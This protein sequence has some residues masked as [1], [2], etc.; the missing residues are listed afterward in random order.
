MLHFNH[1]H[2]KLCWK[3]IKI[4]IEL[5]EALVLPLNWTWSHVTWFMWYIVFIWCITIR[6]CRCLSSEFWKC[7]PTFCLLHLNMLAYLLPLLFW[8]I[9]MTDQPCLSVQNYFHGTMWVTGVQRDMVYSN[10]TAVDCR[11]WQGDIR[12]TKSY[13]HRRSHPMNRTV[14]C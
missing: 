4:A 13:W 1:I 11:M 7:F 8:N 12:L 6:M 2:P 5:K 10:R 3:R 9:K 14:S